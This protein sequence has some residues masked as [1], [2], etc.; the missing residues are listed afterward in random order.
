MNILLFGAPGS[1]KGTQ[2]FRLVKELG[3]FQI[4]TGDLLRQA[5]KDSTDLGKLAQG[6]ISKGDL[7]PDDLVIS[8]VSDV[9]KKNAG[10]NF[11]F[12]GFP[13]TV[14]QAR[15]LDLLLSKFSIK[16]D[17]AFFLDVI[18]S[19]LVSRLSGRRVCKNCNTTYHILTKQTQ[20]EGVCDLCGAEVVQRLDDKE[21]VIRNRLKTYSESTF[22]LKD[23]YTSNGTFVLV[24]GNQLEEV[25][26]SNLLK[27]LKINNELDRVSS[28][29]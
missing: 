6:F 27:H 19:S 28:K 7:V 22:P 5:I 23:Y 25:V 10:K 4:S 11:I 24:D 3:F 14:S 8:L 20:K 2:S 13:R 17:R 18:E 15:A 16:I 29:C 9:I 12:D 1:G 26:Y 21:D